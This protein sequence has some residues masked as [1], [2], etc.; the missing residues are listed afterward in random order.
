MAAMTSGFNVA[1]R[2]YDRGGVDLLLAQ[3]DAALAAPDEALRAAAR[4]LLQDPDLVVVL[5]GY[6]RDEVD[7]AIRDRLR[8]LGATT[9]VQPDGPVPADFVVVLRGYDMAEVDDI[10][11]RAEAA[12]RS[13]DPFLRAS[14]RD[15]LRTAAFQVR[16]RGYDRAQVDH[17]VQEAVR[18]LS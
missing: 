7:E 4:K 17:V 1:L 5:R 18:R 6:A 3:A 10:I 13:D 8:R 16:L 12:M 15:A 11:G 14:T 2:G 9:D